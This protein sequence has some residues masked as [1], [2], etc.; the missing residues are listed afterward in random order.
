MN[1]SMCFKASP[2]AVAR[3]VGSETVILDLAAGEYFG[4]DEIGGRMWE[5]L[6]GGHSVAE[7]CRAMF[8]EFDVA[9][10]LLERDV[11]MFAEDLARRG[12][13]RPV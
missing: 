11:M 7:T 12:L 5:L 9:P 10:A 8:A 4:L 13:I 2:D 1:P 3:L 6:T